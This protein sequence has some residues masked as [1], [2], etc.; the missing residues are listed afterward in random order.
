MA[1]SL[2]ALSPN[3]V[4]KK[5]LEAELSLRFRALCAIQKSGLRDFASAM[6]WG[7]WCRSLAQAALAED[8]ASVQGLIPVAGSRKGS[9]EWLEFV[10]LSDP[11]PA[12]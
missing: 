10:G 11:F 7:Q 4:N 1:E 9:A 6:D 2:H 3:I 12:A 5:S 8:A